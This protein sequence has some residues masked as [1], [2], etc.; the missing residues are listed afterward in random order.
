MTTKTFAKRLQNTVPE[1]ANSATRLAGHAL[2]G[3][4][5]RSSLRVAAAAA[6]E[7]DVELLLRA[8]R[9]EETDEVEPDD[10]A[11]FLSA[12]YDLRESARA[13]LRPAASVF[14]ETVEHAMS[15]A[16]RRKV[17]GSLPSLLVNLV[18]A[19]VTRSSLPEARAAL[20]APPE[21]DEP[22][23][24]IVC[25]DDR[26][27]TAEVQPVSA[28]H[29]DSTAARVVLQYE[30]L[31]DERFTLLCEVVDLADPAVP[32][33]WA[34]VAMT[35]SGRFWHGVHEIEAPRSHRR[36][37]LRFYKTAIGD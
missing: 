8:G 6:V 26:R 28:S 17:L 33:C 22:A 27:F 1:G 32:V 35:S 10:L 34:T 31:P 12:Q 19:G 7:A 4:S 23:F 21:L 30:G 13:A 25:S 18:H 37:A 15:S 36:P 16:A 29:A 11:V 24:E 9:I 2:Q 3:E 20:A 5:N 14:L